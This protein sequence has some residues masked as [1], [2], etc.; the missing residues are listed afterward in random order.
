MESTE[1]GLQMLPLLR[2][3]LCAQRQANVAMRQAIGTATGFRTYRTLRVL[4][5]V[6]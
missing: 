4:N 5:R 2:A 1:S 6:R 3:A